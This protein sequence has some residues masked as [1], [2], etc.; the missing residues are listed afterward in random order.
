M[1]VDNLLRRHLPETTRIVLFKGAGVSV[2]SVTAI[3][4]VT[5]EFV[6]RKAV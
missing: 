1:P 2:A 4:C 6:V 3:T 5:V